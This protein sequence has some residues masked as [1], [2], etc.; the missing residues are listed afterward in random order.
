VLELKKRQRGWIGSTEAVVLMTC[1]LCAAVIC[2]AAFG[3]KAMGEWSDVAAAIGSLN[4]SYSLTGVQSGHPLDPVHPTPVAAWAGSSY[5]DLVDYCDTG[6]CGIQVC[7]TPT[8]EDP[9]GGPVA[10]PDISQLTAD[11]LPGGNLSAQVLF[12]DSSHS[13]G[14]VTITVDGAPHILTIVGNQ[15][16]F[17]QSGAAGGSH[18]ILVTDPSGCGLQQDP[19][20][21]EQ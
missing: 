15:A 14:T 13:G 11:C 3:A 16:T 21:P 2:C 19:F 5:T 17:F 9:P 12:V 18:T 20:C 1:V 7:V 4:Q 6:G 8:R 10:C